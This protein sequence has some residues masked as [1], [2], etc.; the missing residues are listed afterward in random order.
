[1]VQRIRELGHA[2]HAFEREERRV[3]VSNKDEV[4]V[5]EGSGGPLIDGHR[6]IIISEERLDRLLIADPLAEQHEHHE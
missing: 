5:A 6:R 4:V 1:M 3:L 2:V